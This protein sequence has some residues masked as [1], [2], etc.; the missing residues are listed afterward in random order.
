[1]A[2]ETAALSLYN[3]NSSS[4]SNGSASA[5]K[6]LCGVCKCMCPP[7]EGGMLGNDAHG[8]QVFA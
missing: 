6:G 8:W 5:W 3:L 7:M 4:R 2:E 1:M